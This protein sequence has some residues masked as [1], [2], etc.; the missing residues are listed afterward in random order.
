MDTFLNNFYVHSNYIAFSPI[1]FSC[2]LETDEIALLADS[3]FYHDHNLTEVN[4]IFGYEKENIPASYVYEN[5]ELDK[6][7]KDA[8]RPKDSTVSIHNEPPFHEEHNNMS[9]EFETV[10]EIANEN[11]MCE[12]KLL[13]APDVQALLDYYKLGVVPPA[14]A[15]KRMWALN[16]FNNWRNST[17]TLHKIPDNIERYTIE[18]LNKYISLFIIESGTNM[19]P[20]TLLELILQLQ[21]YIN[22]LLDNDQYKFLTEARFKQIKFTLDTRMREL[23]AI[24]NNIPAHKASIVTHDHEQRMWQNGTLGSQTPFQLLATIL[25]QNGL[26][27]ALRAS[28]H[29]QLTTKNFNIIQYDGKKVLQYVEFFSKNH[30][31]G[32]R[33]IKKQPKLVSAFSTDNDRNPIYIY[34]K[35]I[36]HRP[37]NSGDRFYLRPHPNPTSTTWYTCQPLGIQ[38]IAKIIKQ[39]LSK[40]D[41]SSNKFTPHSLRATTA[42]RLYES[43]IEEQVISEITGHTSTAVRH[44]K[45]TS[46]NQLQVASKI[47]NSHKT[48]GNNQICDTQ[49]LP[50]MPNQNTILLKLKRDLKN[51]AEWSVTKPHS[52]DNLNHNFEAPNAKKAMKVSIDGDS[53]IV[54]IVFEG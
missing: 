46:V 11:S 48:R 6:N 8:N 52:E 3:N 17:A 19:R 2:E 43:G 37:I 20:K 10:L 42:T 25:Y 28:E 44:Y 36:S 35:Y 16:K 50:K 40:D 53:N 26:N 32:I 27:F 9:S 5:A 41:E 15:Q 33:D 14:T 31:G 39:S 47:I 54:N 34:Q 49:A 1:S 45:R 29:A 21:Q 30:N 18:D 24:G 4:N 13:Q 38:S 22:R 7:N 51:P 12:K 23:T